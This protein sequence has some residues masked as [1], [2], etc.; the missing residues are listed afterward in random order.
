MPGAAPSADSLQPQQRQMIK[1]A[2]ADAVPP[3][4]PPD[5]LTQ[6]HED[7]TVSEGTYVQQDNSDRLIYPWARDS[8]PESFDPR[9]DPDNLFD[10]D[11]PRE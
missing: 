2:N 6:W 5:P 1:V 11:D 4:A 8:P 10:D 3:E 7:A 9:A